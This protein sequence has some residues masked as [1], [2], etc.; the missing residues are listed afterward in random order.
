MCPPL[1][2]GAHAGA[3]LHYLVL[4]ATPFLKKTS[5]AFLLDRGL[6]LQAIFIDL[7]QQGGP[8]NAQEL[9]R[10]AAVAAGDVQGFAD[11]QAGKTIH[12]VVKQVLDLQP[13]LSHSPGRPFPG[14]GRRRPG[15]RG[16]RP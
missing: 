16:G 6:E 8:G 7:G 13:G 1:V 12:E 15:Q 11:E 10:P 3:P 14:R 9:G 5:R 2:E 4:I